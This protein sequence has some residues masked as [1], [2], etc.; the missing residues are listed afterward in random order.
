MRNILFILLVILCSCGLFT[1]N[2]P[3]FDFVKRDSVI[4]IIKYAPDTIYSKPK[5]IYEYDSIVNIKPFVFEIDTVFR[6][7]H[8]DKYVYDSVKVRFDLQEMLNGNNSL[9]ITNKDA[10]L[11]N[12][13]YKDTVIKKQTAWQ[14]AKENMIFFVIIILFSILVGFL[15]RKK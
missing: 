12:V 5:M 8:I 10:D 9:T 6:K 15:L 2:K 11:K 3:N 4:T 13:S 14:F 7:F 1:S